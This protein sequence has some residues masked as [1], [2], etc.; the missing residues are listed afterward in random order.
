M[1][2]QMQE[3]II[4]K[5]N[6]CETQFSDTEIESNSYS[7]HYKPSFSTHTRARTHNYVQCVCM[8][9]NARFRY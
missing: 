7:A 4:Y 1:C 8:S 3:L 6:V 2:E 9:S 5:I